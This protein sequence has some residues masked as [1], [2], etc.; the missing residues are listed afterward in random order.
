MND[1]ARGA[2]M[3]AA[4]KAEALSHEA[5]C[6]ACAARLAD[7]GALSGGLR[8]LAAHDAGLEAQQRVE[9]ALLAAF[10]ERRAA[11]VATDTAGDTAGVAKVASLEEARA[12]RRWTW[13]HSLSTAAT[14][15]AAAV[16][17]MIIISPSDVPQK[18]G[19]Q[20][21]AEGT[22]PAAGA[23]TGP[24]AVAAAARGEVNS[25]AV[26]ETAPAS[27]VVRGEVASLSSRHET[28]ADVLS[29][30]A[31]S[32]RALTTPAKYEPGA[33]FGGRRGTATAPAEMAAA[34][35]AGGEEYATDFIPLY[36][37]EQTGPV[38]TGQL[39]RVELPRSALSRLGLPVTAE[40]ST[41]RVKADVLLGEDGMA[42]AVRFVR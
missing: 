32:G 22:R 29:R 2:L 13:G 37:A 16:V 36:Q 12:L 42:R 24:A 27:G 34:S 18:L 30:A 20:P 4:A 8:A 3:D 14:A 33:R 10:R 1:V 7:E 40:G 38:V 15:A 17:L 26:A 11:A 19:G 21:L 31:A 35:E 41:D 25:E 5:S 9:A 6:E 39:V 28:R 23:Q